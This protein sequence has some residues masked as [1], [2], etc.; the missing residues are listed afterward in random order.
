VNK[1]SKIFVAGAGGL[2]GSAIVRQLRMQGFENI[3]SP[4]S[5]ELDLT[6]QHATNYFLEKNQIEFIFISAAKVGGIWANN[7]Y[8]ADYCYINMM[9]QNNLIHGAYRNGVKKLL[10]LGSS[11]IYPKNSEIPIKETELLK[12]PLESTNEAYAIAKI[13][14]IKMCDYYRRQYGCDFISVMPTNTYGP[15]DNY[16]LKTAHVLPALIHKFHLAKIREE[17]TVTVWGTGKPRRE[18][19]YSDDI[20]DACLFLMENYSQDGHINLGTGQDYSISEIANMIKQIVDYKGDIV[21]DTSKPDGTFRK[22]MDVSRISKMGWKPK[23]SI[24]IGL[25]LAYKWFVE[26]YD[27]IPMSHKATAL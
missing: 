4:P 25:Q 7:N 3:L 10:F 11:C 12:G 8:P 22:M 27:Q 13:T 15:H 14:G 2:V 16:N 17:K 6:N 26:N 18:V 23:F 9:I 1:N 19:I 24:E 21:F 20:A 5:K